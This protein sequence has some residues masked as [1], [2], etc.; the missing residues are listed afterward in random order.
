MR[1]CNNKRVK[2]RALA[3]QVL[4]LDPWSGISGDM[5]LA[6]LLDADRQNGRLE[7]VLRATVGALGLEGTT[8]HVTH[9][10]ECGID[11]TRL[12]VEDGEAAPLR[13]LQ[14]MEQVISGAPLSWEVRQ[15][16]LRAVRRLAEVEAGVHGCPVEDIHF[17][18]IGAV[19]TLVDI[20][21]AFALMEALGVEHVHVGTIPVGGGL[22]EIE[23]GVVGVPAPATARLLEGYPIVRGPEE[24]EL[25]T[26]TGALLVGE[27]GAVSGGMPAMC[28]QKVGY[29]AGARRSSGVPNVLRVMMGSAAQEP[30]TTDTVVELQTNLDDVSPEV[31]AHLA[32]ELI[33]GPAVDAWTVPVQMK[34]GRAGVVLHALVHLEDEQE[35]VA[36]IFAQSGTLGVRRSTVS[37]YVA[38]RGVLQVQVAGQT[39]AVKW[40]KWAGRVTSVAPEYEDCARVAS[41]AGMVIKEVS[42]L[43]VQA[44]QD[45]LVGGEN[46]E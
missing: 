14:E 1:E 20:V 11:C 15:R 24:R 43:A 16:S 3:C 42:R 13:R 34:K 39:V 2:E 23:H 27:L 35:A 37:R 25:T 8:L 31:V 26:P 44:A 46:G 32:G 40:G 36:M 22:V 29:G 9:D 5:L 41:A 30:V 38:D 33:A 45:A 17:H 21:G 10:V 4:Y 19:D 28:I 18:E 7:L 6:A 12:R